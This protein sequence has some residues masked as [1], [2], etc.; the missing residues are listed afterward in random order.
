MMNQETLSPSP[1]DELHAYVDQNHLTLTE[2]Q[3]KTALTYYSERRLQYS[4]DM[5]GE[6]LTLVLGGEE[7]REVVGDKKRKKIW[8]LV[9]KKFLTNDPGVFATHCVNVHLKKDCLTVR[10]VTV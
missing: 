2:E 7:K 6:D 3:M 9:C 4:D 1:F 10:D 8:C 5:S